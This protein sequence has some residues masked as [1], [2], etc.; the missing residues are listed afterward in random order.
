[1]A[2]NPHP[3]HKAYG[4]SNIKAHVHTQLNLDQMNYD[5]WSEFFSNHCIGYD[6]GDHINT[7]YVSTEANPNLAPTTD[8][9]WK[10]LDSIVKS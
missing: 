3:F 5:L 6:L 7:T 4:V 2:T 1:M 10:K 9:E 8:A